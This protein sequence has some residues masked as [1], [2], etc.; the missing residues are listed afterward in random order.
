M[1]ARESVPKGCKKMEADLVLFHY[2]KCDEAERQRVSGHLV[3]CANCRAFLEDLQTLPGRGEAVD[4]PPSFWAGYSME[5]KRKLN[6]LDDQ[7]FSARLLSF[8]PAWPVPAL[9]V[10]MLVILGLSF[11]LARG[12]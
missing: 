1:R 6:A 9:S 3:K 10:A 2:G 8:L 5:V 11:V 7:R 12:C 4:P